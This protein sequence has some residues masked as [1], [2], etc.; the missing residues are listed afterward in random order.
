MGT[1]EVFFLN[2]CRVA[3]LNSRMYCVLLYCIVE[4]H[5]LECMYCNSAF[6]SG[7]CHETVTCKADE[8]I[9]Q[10]FNEGIIAPHLP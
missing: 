3:D 8:V 5:A 2:Y 10:W 4:R 1:T 7:D 9:S 6:E